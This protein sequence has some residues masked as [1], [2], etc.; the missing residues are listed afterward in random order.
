MG[1]KQRKK[2]NFKWSS[3][4][5]RKRIEGDRK[6]KAEL[7][8]KGYKFSRH[9]KIADLRINV[10]EDMEE[11]RDSLDES[12]ASGIILRQATDVVIGS[13]LHNTSRLV[14]V[15]SASS[16]LKDLSKWYKATTR[17]RL[18]LRLLD[19]VV[20]I[21]ENLKIGSVLIRDIEDE[22][23]EIL[24]E[25]AKAS[26]KKKIEEVKFYEFYRKK[27]EIESEKRRKNNLRRG[28]EKKEAARLKI[29]AEKK[30]AEKKRILKNEAEVK[31]ALIWRGKLDEKIE[32]RR[33]SI[34]RIMKKGI[35]NR[36]ELL[37]D[38]ALEIWTAG[39]EDALELDRQSG[40]NRI[41]YGYSPLIGFYTFPD[42]MSIVYKLRNLVTETIGKKRREERKE[43]K[44]LQK[45][46][47]KLQK[48]KDDK[49][50]S[51]TCS[52]PLPRKYAP[53]TSCIA[54]RTLASKKIGRVRIRVYKAL[55]NNRCTGHPEVSPFWKESLEIILD[56]VLQEIFGLIENEEKWHHLVPNV[57]DVVK[58]LKIEVGPMVA[59]V[60]KEF[61]ILD[62]KKAVEREKRK[63][64]KNH[65]K[66]LR[67]LKEKVKD[68]CLS[69]LSEKNRD[70]FLKEFEKQKV[71]KKEFDEKERVRIYVEGYLRSYDPEPI[72]VKPAEVES[73]GG[74]KSYAVCS[75]C[76]DQFPRN[77]EILDS[78]NIC[79]VCPDCYNIG[80]G[81]GALDCSACEISHLHPGESCTTCAWVR[82]GLEDRER[83]DPWD[84]DLED[85]DA[86]TE[87]EYAPGDKPATLQF[88]KKHLTVKYLSSCYIERRKGNTMVVQDEKQPRLFLRVWPKGRRAFY[89]NGFSNG[90]FV[91][92]ELG[93][94]PGI[95]LRHARL[96]TIMFNHRV[97]HAGGVNPA[98]LFDV[99]EHVK[100]MDGGKTGLRHV[101]TY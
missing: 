74:L 25:R 37:S 49:L 86:P 28:K 78:K 79:I 5:Q 18:D 32:S 10:A 77:D 13:G 11:L 40:E 35:K 54:L 82:D 73:L 75:S 71:A 36:P 4:E 101:N 43:E 60:K 33:Q 22:R 81:D 2:I 39:M 1:G 59:S 88:V 68:D 85:D 48:E 61:R 16:K 65:T 80:S 69:N 7:M 14:E 29:E 87:M 95:R 94:W 91:N 55:N 27:K 9:F 50:K 38:E 45:E 63:R 42:M 89:W 19:Q 44:K 57:T 56:P 8:K 52:N 3:E 99:L 84:W 70:H 83:F 24:V 90:K 12:T 41:S 26:E 72:H 96:A 66:F 20:I 53:R 21:L 76:G 98:E 46:E 62:R 93:D 97:Y 30:A 15:V 58:L 100:E 47:K 6:L 34:I 17:D 64:E 92:L 51:E 31:R 23:A 67:K